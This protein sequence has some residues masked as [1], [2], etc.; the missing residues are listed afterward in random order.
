MATS[1]NMGGDAQNSN[2]NSKVTPQLQSQSDNPASDISTSTSLPMN[3]PGK[4]GILG[5]VNFLP[6]SSVPTLELF[7]TKFC[8][9]ICLL[10]HALQEAVQ[11]RETAQKIALQALRDASATETLVRSLK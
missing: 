1:L 10:F 11:Q 9:F 8:G 7:F 6:E 3:L 5:K 4:L 2:S